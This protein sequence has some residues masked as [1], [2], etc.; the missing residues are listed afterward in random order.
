MYVNISLTFK[1][2]YKYVSGRRKNE[3]VIFLIW[4]YMMKNRGGE[5]VTKLT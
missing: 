2:R 1:I 3:Y 5:E 4:F